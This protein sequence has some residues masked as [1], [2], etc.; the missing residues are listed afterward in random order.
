MLTSPSTGSTG[1]C[2][3]QTTTTRSRSKGNS[4]R[5]RS[6]SSNSNSSN[7]SDSSSRSSSSNNNSSSS[8]SSSSIGTLRRL[9]PG[10]T[11]VTIMAAA[12]ALLLRGVI[13]TVGGAI[14]TVGWTIV[15]WVVAHVTLAT[16][17]E[18]EAAAVLEAVMTTAGSVTPHRASNASHNRVTTHR[19]TAEGHRPNSSMIS[20]ETSAIATQWQDRAAAVVAVVCQLYMVVVVAHRKACL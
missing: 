2:S 16:L 4:S 12:V 10:I 9:H 6:S 3:S 14:V 5:R 20:S 7:S 15:G 18:G 1:R 8:S 13:V 17:I 19:I 11:T